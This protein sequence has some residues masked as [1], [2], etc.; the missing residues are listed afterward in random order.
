MSKV[1]FVTGSSRGLGRSVVEAALQAGDRVVAT[2]R[3]PQSLE[4]LS[5]KWGKQILTVRLDVTS[6]AEAQEAIKAAT[7]HFGR[8]DVVVNNAGKADVAAIEDCD[9]SSF[10]R[11]VETVFLGVVNVT[12][13]AL[14]TLRQQGAGHFIQVSS[15]G[16]RMATPGLAAYQS[17]KWAVTGFSSTLAAEVAPLGIKVSILEPGTMHTDMPGGSSMDIHAVS[18]PYKATV[19]A[20]A[21]TMP[22]SYRDAPNDPAQVAQLVMRL[23]A[24]E[25]PPLRLLVGKDAVEYGED[26]TRKLADKDAKWRN[27]SQSVNT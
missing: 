6:T 3:S 17:S 4:D 9:I 25:E 11:L 2:A 16:A 10:R 8:I 15:A 13:A 12:K 5:A 19:G 1:W 7:D 14:P 26:A 18:E 20:V 27:L 22:G 23:A 21:E 24:M